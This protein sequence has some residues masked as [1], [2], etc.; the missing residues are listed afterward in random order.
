M[1][2]NITEYVS[3]LQEQINQLNQALALSKESADNQET[4]LKAAVKRVWDILR[5]S[6]IRRPDLYLLYP[7]LEAVIARELVGVLV[8]GQGRELESANETARNILGNELPEQGKDTDYDEIFFLADQVTPCGEMLPWLR[9]L[10]GQEVDGALIYLKRPDSDDPDSGTWLK[11][12]A[13]PIKQRS[14]GTVLGAALLIIDVTEYV[15]VEKRAADVKRALEQRLLATSAAHENLSVLADKLGNQ[16]WHDQAESKDSSAP[17][18][19]SHHG[20]LALVVDDIHV[21][22]ILL[23]SQ[24]SKMGFTVHCADTGKDAVEAATKHAYDLILMDCDMP[25][26][27]GYEATKSIRVQEVKSGRHT[28]I[29]ALTAYNRTSEREKCLASGMDEYL[30]KGFDQGRLLQ[31]IETIM[32]QNIAF[33]KAPSAKTISLKKLSG[34]SNIPDMESLESIYGKDELKEILGLYLSTTGSLL[35]CLESALAE[36]DVRATHHYAYCIKGPSASLGNFKLAKLCEDTAESAIRGKWFDADDHFAEMRSVVK[37]LRKSIASNQGNG[38]GALP[39]KTTA[40]PQVA[41]CMISLEKQVGRSTAL[42]MASAFL[43]D[44]KD[45]LQVM[46][47]AIQQRNKEKLR[48]AAH[49]L[50]GCSVSIHDK[51]TQSMS[52]K[53]EHLATEAKWVEAYNVYDAVSDL[54]S[55][56]E[57]IVQDYVA[58]SR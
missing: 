4:A 37:A 12:S 10:A 21:N 50:A 48:G 28:P 54:F 51:E 5:I 24:L 29:L 16:D 30:Q 36:R 14:D 33:S 43:E 56:T 13:V 40:P 31:V 26:M 1:T 15:Q 2:D 53:L 42:L 25:I 58:E 41:S 39:A 6:D 34:E 27:D 49:K 57:K 55:K 3:T 8:F 17:E 35:Q 22:Q 7:Q 18:K 38:S 23:S 44:T 47:N 11:S 46:A 9:G 19:D 52:Q 45:V 32:Q 20:R